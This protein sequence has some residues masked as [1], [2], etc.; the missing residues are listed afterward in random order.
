VRKPGIIPDSSDISGNIDDVAE[1]LDSWTLNLRDMAALVLV[2]H[3][4]L[5]ARFRCLM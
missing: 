1:P 4:D 5:P 3:C 2:R